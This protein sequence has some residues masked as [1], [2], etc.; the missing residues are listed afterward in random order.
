[1][2]TCFHQQ[3]KGGQHRRCLPIP[4]LII[5]QFERSKNRKHKRLC[6]QHRCDFAPFIA[7]CAGNLGPHAKKVLQR[8]SQ[9]LAENWS[10]PYSSVAHFVNSRISISLVRSTSHCLPGCRILASLISSAR[11]TYDQTEGIYTLLQH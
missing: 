10:Q 2:R 4:T 8:L 9:C 11:Y 7:S 1:M 3:P 6:M 5:A